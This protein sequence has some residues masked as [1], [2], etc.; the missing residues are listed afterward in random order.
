MTITRVRVE[1][2]VVAFKVVGV[3]LVQ[4]SRNVV[5][6]HWVRVEGLGGRSRFGGVPKS[7]TLEVGVC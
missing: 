1:V 6:V 5:G 7:I 2:G 4:G 3:V